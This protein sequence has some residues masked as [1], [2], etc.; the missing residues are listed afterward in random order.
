[1]KRSTP[2]INVI[3]HEPSSASDIRHIKNIN[4]DTYL[5]SITK[6]LRNAPLTNAE[7]RYVID[8]LK[9]IHSE[10]RP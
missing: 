4:H 10:S 9:S 5:R 3:L 2:K 8:T 1:M 6:T 7:R